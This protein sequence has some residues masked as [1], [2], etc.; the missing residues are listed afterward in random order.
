MTAQQLA[1]MPHVLIASAVMVIEGIHSIRRPALQGKHRPEL[2][3]QAGYSL[4]CICGGAARLTAQTAIV[5]AL[6]STALPDSADV[7]PR[8]VEQQTGASYQPAFAGVQLVL[9]SMSNWICRGAVKLQQL[10]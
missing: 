5:A 1:D 4:P 10:L 9:A 2:T 8:C 3:C 7:R 6:R